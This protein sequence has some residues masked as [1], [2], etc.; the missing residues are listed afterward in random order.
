MNSKIFRSILIPFLILSISGFILSL[1]LH[2]LS[3]LGLQTPFGAATWSLHIGIFVIWIPA[4][5]IGLRINAKAQQKDYW[6]NI[7]AGCPRWMRYALYG[8]FAYAAI[9]FVAAMATQSQ[10]PRRQSFNKE[11]PP[12]VLRMFSGHW[13]VFYGA[14]FCILYSAY[15]RGWEQLRRTCSNGHPVSFDAQFCDRCGEKLQAADYTSTSP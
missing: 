3:L 1:S 9:N 11:A 14:G 10:L 4:V 15:S 7:L 5:L 12:E 6:K 13:M 8:L 2:L